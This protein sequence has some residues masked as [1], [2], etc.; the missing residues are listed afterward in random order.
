MSRY[1]IEQ[2]EH[3][4]GIVVLPRTEV[5]AL[6]GEELLEGVE[7]RDGVTHE[8]STVAVGGLFVFIGADPGTGWLQGQLAQDEDGFLLTGAD[9]GSH[10][11][12]P[13][14][15]VLETSTPGVFCVGDARSRSVKR[16]AAAVGEGAMAVR[17]VFERFEESGLAMSAAPG[18]H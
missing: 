12:G 8:T 6:V 1:L 15:L 18:G 4:P 7:L 11:D 17:L 9:L 13:V 10:D 5:T 16:V 2:I 3:H 14:P